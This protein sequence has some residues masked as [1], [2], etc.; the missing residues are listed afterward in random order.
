M[1]GTSSFKSSSRF[2]GACKTKT[3]MLN[4]GKFCWRDKLRS[5]VMNISN[6]FSASVNRS[7]FFKPAQPIFGTVS[8]RWPDSSLASRRS[9]HSSRRIFTLFHTGNHSF[10]SFFQ[11]S[12]YLLSCYSGKPFEKIIYGLSCFE[13][14]EQSLDG[15]TC[16]SKHWSSSHYV[17]GYAN[18]FVLHSL[19]YSQNQF[20]N[21]D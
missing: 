7:P 2:V 1:L 16:S 3:A 18:D 20:E 14:I 19:Q 4:R 6:C 12:D 15:H 13:I 10:F 8:T 21:Q 5:T 17:R 11:K 9:T